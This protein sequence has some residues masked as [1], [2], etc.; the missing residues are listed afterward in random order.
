VS[1]EYESVGGLMRLKS[2]VVRGQG[3]DVTLHVDGTVEER[4][5]AGQV[6]SGGEYSA[7]AFGGLFVTCS[8]NTQGCSVT[9]SGKYFGRPA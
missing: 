4:S 2:V 6:L 8:K 7:V 1:G 3:T 9:V 5:V